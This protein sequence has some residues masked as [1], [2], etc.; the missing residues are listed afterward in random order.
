MTGKKRNK[1]SYPCQVYH[2]QKLWRFGVH[3]GYFGGAGES[4]R[5]LAFSRLFLGNPGNMA[6]GCCFI[7]FKSLKAKF[8]LMATV[9]LRFL[10]FGLSENYNFKLSVCSVFLPCWLNRRVWLTGE[11]IQVLKR[12][13]ALR[14]KIAPHCV[15][16]DTVS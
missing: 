1:K 4:G 12:F 10:F 5:T 8:K 2:F 11:Q 9:W 3:V 15:P 13:V 14:G 6:A 7:S 16:N